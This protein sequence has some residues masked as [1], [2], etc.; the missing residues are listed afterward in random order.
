METSSST[1]SLSSAC[2]R[3][4]AGIYG[5]QMQALPRGHHGDTLMTSLSNDLQR[6]LYVLYVFPMQTMRTIVLFFLGVTHE[7]IVNTSRKRMFWTQN[8]ALINIYRSDVT[9]SIRASPISLTCSCWKPFDV[10]AES[11]PNVY[12]RVTFF[13]SRADGKSFLISVVLVPGTSDEVRRR[14]LRTEHIIRYIRSRNCDLVASS[15]SAQ[16][17]NLKHTR[18]KHIVL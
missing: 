12:F 11:Y 7:R 9:H 17:L 5:L 10:A 15:N 16:C 14:A 18:Q 6:I 8:T 1:N 2:C 3:Y 4:T 13:G